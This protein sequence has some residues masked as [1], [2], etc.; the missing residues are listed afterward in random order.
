[1]LMDKVKL[2]KK[3]NKWKVNK[4]GNWNKVKKEE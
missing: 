1:M 4:K 2:R 3:E